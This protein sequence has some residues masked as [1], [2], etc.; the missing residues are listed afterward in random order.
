M[1][2]NYNSRDSVIIV[3]MSQTGYKQVFASGN[4]Y[5]RIWTKTQLKY[6]NIVIILGCYIL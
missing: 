5:T 2:L 6:L 4:C 3:Q 1:Q